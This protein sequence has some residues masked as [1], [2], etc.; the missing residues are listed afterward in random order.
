VRQKS[1]APNCSSLFYGTRD[2]RSRQAP[3]WASATVNQT[4]LASQDV[5]LLKHS[6]LVVALLSD[7]ACRNYGKFAL[8]A[9]N[10]GKVFANSSSNCRTVNFDFDGNSTSNQVEATGESK[11]G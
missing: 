2:K 10:L 7:S 11:N 3:Y 9:E 5:A 4:G 1:A 8:D 6:H